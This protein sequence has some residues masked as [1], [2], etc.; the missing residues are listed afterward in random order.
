MPVPPEINRDGW[1]RTDEWS[2]TVYS[3]PLVSVEATSVV[4]DRRD[5]YETIR[6]YVSPEIE[7]SPRSVFT[8]GLSIRPSLRGRRT[9]KELLGFV[10]EHATEKFRSHLHKYGLVG[11]RHT[12]SKDFQIGDQQH[13]KAFEF[14]AGYP[15]RQ[16]GPE[17]A[18][19]L[20]VHVVA[21]LW[22]TEDSFALGGGFYPLED[23]D[24]VLEGGDADPPVTIEAN[25]K[26]DKRELYDCIADAVTT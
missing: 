26:R 16:N 25:P 14:V 22:P 2:E 8:T 6:P 13:V 20:P 10:G 19:Q 12:D 21:V 7:H 23:L 15:I 18:V 5:L 9:A 24:S 1:S 11:V 4:Y 17:T 3:A